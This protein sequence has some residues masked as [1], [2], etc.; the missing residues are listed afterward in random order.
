MAVYKEEVKIFAVYSENKR[1]V[2]TDAG[3][4][5]VRAGGYLAISTGYGGG[6]LFSLSELELEELAQD[7]PG[8][9]ASFYER[10]LLKALETGH[11]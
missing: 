11:E 10:K 6:W 8:E 4:V 1:Q 5:Y 2:L 7:E 9:D 3:L